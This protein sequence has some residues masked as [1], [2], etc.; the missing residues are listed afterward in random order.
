MGLMGLM[1]IVLA[2]VPVMTPV[3]FP[4]LMAAVGEGAA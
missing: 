2:V 1:A 4:N 3:L